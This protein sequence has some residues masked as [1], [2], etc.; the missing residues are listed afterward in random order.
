MT[1]FQAY[2]DLYNGSIVP[3]LTQ[4]KDVEAVMLD[5]EAKGRL[6]AEVTHH[7]TASHAL[8]T[9]LAV[10]PY[11]T[12]QARRACVASKFPSVKGAVCDGSNYTDSTQPLTSMRICRS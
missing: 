12:W 10:L 4:Q 8:Y 6:D 5:A 2:N 1:A 11:L 9:Q 3:L 7:P